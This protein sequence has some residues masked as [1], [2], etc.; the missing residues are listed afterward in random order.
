VPTYLS[1][2]SSAAAI[3]ARLRRLS[4]R[5]DQDCARLY[6]EGGLR[7]EQRWFGVMNQLARHDS[8][9]IKQ[10]AEALRISHA[11]ISE[12]RKSLLAAGLI[13]SVPDP[14]DARSVRLCL[15]AAGR[16]LFERMAPVWET[17][18]AVSEELDA[19]AGGLAEALDRLDQALDRE[20]LYARARRRLPPDDQTGR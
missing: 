13:E 16:D 11:S 15:S 1:R 7:F 14:R 19:E 6:A 20:P 4:E 18:E 2:P 8:L 3:G 12:T 10:L 5:I 9:S 17:L